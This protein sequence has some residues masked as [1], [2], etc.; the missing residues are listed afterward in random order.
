MARGSC[1]PT[2]GPGGKERLPRAAPPRGAPDRVYAG[3]VLLCG[4]RAGRPQATRG[5]WNVTRAAPSATIASVESL[6]ERLLAVMD[7]KSHWAYPALTRPGLSRD[8]LLL[9]FRHEYLVYVR[10]FPV[11]LGARA[12]SDPAHRRSAPR[13][14]REPL[15]GAN[16]GPVPDRCAPEALPAHDGGPRLRGRVVRRRRRLAP[17]GGAPLPRLPA[18]ACGCSSVASSRGASDDLRRGERERTSRARR[19]VRTKIWRGSGARA[20]AG[21]S[22]TAARPRRWS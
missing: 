12:R 22:S 20:P 14:R 8:Q 16:R 17:P 19:N 11:L 6:R 21:A 5:F 4:K 1:R 15:R 7:R 2:H 3:P 13:A 9:H 10:D 18:R